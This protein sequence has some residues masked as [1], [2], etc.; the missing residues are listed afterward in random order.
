MQFNK[1]MKE[2]FTYLSLIFGI[3]AYTDNRGDRDIVVILQLFQ[4]YFFD[5]A[6]Q[7]FRVFKIIIDV[8]FS[9]DIDLCHIK[10]RKEL[11]L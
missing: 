11:K 6:Y 5:L 4:Q 7:C 9:G 8:Y 1:D 10:F 3:H 2:V